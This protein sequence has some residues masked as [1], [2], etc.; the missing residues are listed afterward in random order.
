MLWCKHLQEFPA[1][2]PVCTVELPLRGARVSLG[3]DPVPPDTG[4]FAQAL[5]HQVR[6]VD[7]GQ[8]VP[9]D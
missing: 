7:V 5:I 4:L 2:H 8:A 9:D 1:I 6:R 3:G